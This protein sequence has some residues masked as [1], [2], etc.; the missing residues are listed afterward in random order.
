MAQHPGSFEAVRE[1]PAA[2]AVRGWQDRPA[3][4]PRETPP[5]EPAGLD[6]PAPAAETPVPTQVEAEPQKPRRLRRLLMVGASLALLSR[7][8]HYG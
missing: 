2:E 5:A 1:V 8:G 3:A 7:G 6:R 4:D